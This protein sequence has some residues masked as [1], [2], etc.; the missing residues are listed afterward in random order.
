MLKKYPLKIFSAI[1]LAIICIAIVVVSIFG[2][3]SSIELGGGSQIEI[4]ISYTNESGDIVDGKDQALDYVKTVKKTLKDYRCSVDS[5]FVED[6]LADTYLVIRI[7]KT[8]IKNADQLRQDLSTDL[9]ISIERVSNVDILSSYF[10]GDTLLYIGLSILIILA[11]SFFLG[12]IRYNLLSGV[13]LSFALL[14]NIILSLA[15]LIITRV[16]FS[17]VSLVAMLLM[18][19]L[20]QFAICMILERNKENLKSKV[21]QSKSVA[22]NLMIS[23]KQNKALLIFPAVLALVSVILLFIPVRQI[24]LSSV[25]LLLLLVSATYTVLCLAPALITYLIEI[26]EMRNKQKLSTQNISKKK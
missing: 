25:S 9:N 14:H 2:I 20:M 24:Q 1:S 16:Q 13:A 3:K 15:L 4:Q 7:A 11:L 26:K 19:T 21:Y 18:S 12:W 8:N 10:S 17:M 22:E 23:T 6:K 5:Y